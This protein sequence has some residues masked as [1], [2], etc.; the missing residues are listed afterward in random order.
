MEFQKPTFAMSRSDF[1][2]SRFG[3]QSVFLSKSKI[4]R[5]TEL[6]IGDTHDE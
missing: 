2:H 6:Q 4:S 1:L 5:Y 3:L